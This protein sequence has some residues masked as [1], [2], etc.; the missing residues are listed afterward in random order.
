VGVVDGAG[1]GLT[2]RWCIVCDVGVRGFARVGDQCGVV[3][4][5][6]GSVG[7]TVKGAVVGDW[8]E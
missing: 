8:F 4:R 3:K 7:W 1:R 5:W 2:W 6:R